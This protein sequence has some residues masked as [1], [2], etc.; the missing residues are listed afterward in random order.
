MTTKY[1]FFI[2]V[3]V[4]FGAVMGLAQNYSELTNILEPDV[5]ITTTMP[6]R[7]YDNFSNCT[8]PYFTP[9][10]KDNG[11]YSKM[12]EGDLPYYF[13]LVD[14]NG[15]SYIFASEYNSLKEEYDELRNHSNE[16]IRLKYEILTWSDGNETQ[17][18]N[19]VIETQIL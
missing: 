4:I 3:M 10:E 19:L 18:I 12:H 6:N 7:T 11:E 5:E 9:I 14:K 15:T 13:K 2:G 8:T 17:K 16:K 1:Y